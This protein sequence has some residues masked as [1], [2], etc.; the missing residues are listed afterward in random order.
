VNANET[1]QA[2]AAGT[3][4]TNSAVASASYA[5]AP[6]LPAPS[7]S[8]AS[9][10]FLTSLTVS[11][12]DATAG[13]TIYYTTNGAV[14][15]S[16]SNVYSGPITLTA[17]ETLQAIASAT[18]YTN[19][20]AATATYTLSTVDPIYINYPANGFTASGLSL[21][22]GASITGGM[23][24]LTDGGTGEVR[25]AWT[26]TKLP[27]SAFTTDFTFQLKNAVADGFTFTIQNDHKGI[28]AFGD[29]GGGLGSQGILNSVSLKFDIYSDAGEGTDS[30]GIYTHGAAPT[31]S[32]VDMTS[33]GVIL[34]SG[35]LMHAHL[36]YSG[37]TLTMTLTDT[38]TGAVYTHQFT[39]NIPSAVGGTNAYVGF[40][41]STGSRSATQQITSWTY[42]T[43]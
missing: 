39:V 2:I 43:P 14:P 24:E 20:P 27:V 33:S 3:G 13:T 21:N 35:D 10:T 22:Y 6:V 37:T 4:Y 19:S 28:W 9:G 36:V 5:I 12:S 42:T 11:L 18:G 41:A 34:K 15:N 1:L 40:T 7:F 29:S 17:T 26:T 25:T 30:T 31:T 23:L 16:S 32:S 8:V 38:V